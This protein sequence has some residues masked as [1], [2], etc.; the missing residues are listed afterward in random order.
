MSFQKLNRVKK[1]KDIDLKKLTEFNIHNLIVNQF[2]IEIN[3]QVLLN[4][5]QVL[6]QLK[7]QKVSNC[8]SFIYKF[9]ETA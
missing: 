3:L 5:S 6:N 8:I 1:A 2:Q 9:L 4:L 7:K